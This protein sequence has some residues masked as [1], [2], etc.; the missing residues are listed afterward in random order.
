V[1]NKIE[2]LRVFCIA[3]IIVLPK[4]ARAQNAASNNAAGPNI[5]TTVRAGK[6]PGSLAIDAVTNKIYVANTDGMSVT[7]ID[8]A[9][10]TSATVKLPD[11]PVFMVVNQNTNK[12]YVRSWRGKDI[13]VIDGATNLVTTVPTGWL[14][15][16]VRVNPV[17]NKV[18]VTNSFGNG[19]TVIDGATNKTTRVTTGWANDLVVNPVTNKIYVSCESAVGGH[20]GTV[21][22]IDGA[23]N[24][25]MTIPIETG[26][27]PHSMAVNPVANKIYIV[28]TTAT[29]PGEKLKTNR[30]L[31][32]DGA[33]NATATVETGT[34]MGGI[35][36]NPET[37]RI[38]VA[39]CQSSSVTV[40]DGAT[41]RTR[42]VP[43]GW[44]PSHVD[45]NPVTNKIYI[46][47]FFITDATRRFP[48]KSDGISDETNTMTVIDGAS[49]RTT[50][51]K[52]VSDI[53]YLGI[54]LNTVTNRIYVVAGG[55]NDVTVLDGDFNY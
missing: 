22:V 34:G 28:E 14:A 35:A 55:S 25:T 18:Y 51:T 37:N 53:R 24:A 11:N 33:T 49:Y 43:T 30:V 5:I 29:A 47:Y 36:V 52:F 41:N 10:N 7:V 50:T 20:K 6:V 31:V 23:T 39:N 40:I 8:G 16:I 9:T 26:W 15:G 44:C 27:L 32:I 42:Q 38:F 46:T 17:T 21:S 4:I 48:F 12:I 2:S 19:V 45:V 1:A 13:W 54:A 3:L